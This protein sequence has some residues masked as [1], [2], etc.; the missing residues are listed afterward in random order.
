[1]PGID[2]VAESEPSA[3]ALEEPTRHPA[4]EA[5]VRSA[6]PSDAGRGGDAVGAEY[7]VRPAGSL[8]ASTRVMPRAAG[9]ARQRGV[10]TWRGTLKPA[11]AGQKIQNLLV[12]DVTATAMTALP[13]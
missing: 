1:M 4:A 6:R 8:L 7:R 11:E 5:G 13:G 9:T 10:A 12:V 2:G 3:D